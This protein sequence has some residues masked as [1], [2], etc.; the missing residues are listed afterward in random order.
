VPPLQQP[1]GQVMESQA[2]LPEVV[3]QRP[4]GQDA[5]AAPPFPH[6]EGDSEG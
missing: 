5:Q 2:Q 3:S 4:L 1:L 6:V